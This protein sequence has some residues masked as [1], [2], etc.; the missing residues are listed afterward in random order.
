[1]HG[2][3]LLRVGFQRTTKCSLTPPQ[4]SHEPQRPRALSQM[5]ANGPWHSA[6]PGP[7][8]YT[9]GPSDSPN[10][11]FATPQRV[12]GA[13]RPRAGC[14]RLAKIPCTSPARRMEPSHPEQGPD[15]SSNGHW[16]FTS[17]RTRPR[18]PAP[19]PSSSPN[20]PWHNPSMDTGPRDL[21]QSGS[22][23]GSWH[24]SSMRTDPS[25]FTWGSSGQPNGP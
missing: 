14:Q 16:H 6:C 20:D 24:M 25:N 2:P 23:N 21:A 19:G 15:G 11:P 1:M 7:R 9:R 22:P 3:Q 4:R 10:D 18:N 12:H 13:Q 8:D 17:M 5:L